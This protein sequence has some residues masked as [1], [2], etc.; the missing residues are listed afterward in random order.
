MEWFSVTLTCLLASTIKGR[1]GSEAS[2]WCKCLLAR[3]RSCG[4]EESTTNTSMRALGMYRC[5]YGR[6]SSLPPTE[7]TH[8]QSGPTS[9]QKNLFVSPRPGSGDS[10][11]RNSTC[12][13]PLLMETALKPCVGCVSCSRLPVAK[14]CSRLVLPAPSRPRTRTWVPADS[15]GLQDCGTYQIR[16]GSI[17][18][19]Y[20]AD[21][22][23]CVVV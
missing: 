18:P 23:N 3:G 16:A 17:K 9:K 20:K 21:V 15:A 5:Q 2:S 13:S 10:L 4:S 11:S 19:F 22:S 12:R 6:S 1:W 8:T 7:K 14:Q